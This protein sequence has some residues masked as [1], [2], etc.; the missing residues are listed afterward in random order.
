MRHHHELPIGGSTR[1][2]PLGERNPS[3]KLPALAWA[4]LQQGAR[5]GL[6]QASLTRSSETALAQESGLRLDEPSKQR[7]E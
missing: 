6:A 4:R 3:L 1:L 7:G 2:R 5:Q